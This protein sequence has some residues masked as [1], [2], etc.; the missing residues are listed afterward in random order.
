MGNVKAMAF[1]NYEAIL[2]R[3]QE[4]WLEIVK[5]TRGKK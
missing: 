4:E 5:E 3:F 2:N 1:T